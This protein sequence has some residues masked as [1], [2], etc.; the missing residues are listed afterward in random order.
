MSMIGLEHLSIRPSKDE[1]RSARKTLTS[2]STSDGSRTL[3]FSTTS[4]SLWPTFFVSVDTSSHPS[5]RLVFLYTPAGMIFLQN[6]LSNGKC[7]EIFSKENPSSILFMWFL[8]RSHQIQAFQQG[9]LK[10]CRDTNNSMK[11]FR[12]SQTLQR[13]SRKSFPAIWYSLTSL[14]LN[15]SECFDVKWKTIHQFAKLHILRS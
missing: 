3:Q 15:A 13:S 8:R 4:V 14:N 2:S 9:T 6:S 1:R 7:E 12:M 11:G 5:T 10:P